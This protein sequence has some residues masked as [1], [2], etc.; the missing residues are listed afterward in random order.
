MKANLIKDYLVVTELL[1]R[2]R[3]NAGL[4]QKQLADLLNVPQS[5]ISKIETGE[6]RIN[7]IELRELCKT[8]NSNLVEFAAMLEKE[9]NETQS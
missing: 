6:R 1:Y 5:F 8:L 4:T 7:L 2:L 9:L 3:I